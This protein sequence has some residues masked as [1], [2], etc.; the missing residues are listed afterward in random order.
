MILPTFAG[1]LLTRSQ[2][3]AYHR[4]LASS[5]RVAVR[6]QLLNPNEK[7]RAELA[8]AT[9]ANGIGVTG[10]QVDV[11]TTGGNSQPTRQLTLSLL[12][13]HRRFHLEPDSV[14]DYGLFVGDLIRVFRGDYV[15]ELGGWVWCPVIT[16]PV[17]GFQNDYPEV[18]ITAVGKES[19]LLDPYLTLSAVTATRGTKVTTAIKRVLEESGEGKIALGN[20]SARI[21]HRFNLPRLSQPWLAVHRLAAN[22]GGRFPYYDGRG[23]LRLKLPGTKDPVYTFKHG[24]GGVLLQAPELAYDFTTFHN[25]AD[26]SGGTPKKTKKKVHVVETVAASNPL[27][28]GALARNGHPRHSVIVVDDSNIL[29]RAQAIDRGRAA[30]AGGLLLG[31]DPSQSQFDTLPI[32]HLEELD[33]VRVQ[34]EGG[35]IL[36]KMNRWTIPLDG[37]TMPVG[38]HRVQRWRARYRP[39]RRGRRHHK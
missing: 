39:T 26:V 33:L 2:L 10:G 3:E 34:T 19:L 14:A 20:L 35:S 5:H 15:S 8:I 11:D 30:V 9:P 37:D 21:G 6:L 28:P 18:Q 1:K 4:A 7:V 13:P 38:L 29:R 17:T 16:G 12:D 31:T 23:V 36:L 25:T 27:S 22:A 24:A 32:P